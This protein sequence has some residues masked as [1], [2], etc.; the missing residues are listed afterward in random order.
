MNMKS[1]VSTASLLVGSLATLAPSLAS[2]DEPAPASTI[3]FSTMDRAG[4]ENALSVSLGFHVY[5]DSDGDVTGQRLDIYGQD[6]LPNMDLGIYSSVSFSNLMIEDADDINAM[7]N[8]EVGALYRMKGGE[9]LDVVLRG[10]FS[11]AT[12]DEDEGVLANL[13]TAYQ[14][15]GDVVNLLPDKNYMRFSAS[16][17]YRA[18]NAFVRAD[19][20]MDIGVSGDEDIA[21]YLLH[22][23]VGA[24][25]SSGKLT[26]TGEL[27]SVGILDDVD[28]EEEPDLSDRF[29]H[30]GA[31]SARYDAGAVKPY[32]SFITPL[33]DDAAGE[34]FI[35]TVGADA[36]F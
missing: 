9:N 7:S 34:V 31:I 13:A 11:I 12:A 2:A 16:P 28:G 22:A 3:G 5:D 4:T 18:G 14:R 27:V 21:D 25:V 36:N 33:D 1:F 35:F 23:N 20:G 15:I 30:T 26:V 19:V 10:G 32:L 29:V 8:L 6:Y 17:I 24:G